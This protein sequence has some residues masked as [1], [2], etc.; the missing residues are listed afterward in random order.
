MKAFRE[1]DRVLRG[2]SGKSGAA[3]SLGPLVLANVLL[4]AFYGLCMGIYAI[5]NR[6][7]P[8]FRFLFADLIK[9]PLLFLLTL[10]VTFPSLYVFSALVRSPF[11]IVDLARLLMQS[12]GVVVALLAAFGP[13]VGF[14]SVTTRNYPFIVLLNVIVCGLSSVFGLVTFLSRLEHWLTDKTTSKKL[15]PEARDQSSQ[16]S[17]E[18]S[19]NNPQQSDAT[20]SSAEVEEAEQPV[21]TSSSSARRVFQVWIFVFGLVGLQM[22]WILRPFIGSPHAEFAWFKPRESSFFESVANTIRSL[23]G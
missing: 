15:S 3:V 13:I 18:N 22:S 17:T 5:A 2:D 12:M 16:P 19:D 9:V 7:Q 8:E 20:P 11:S 4:A 6:D 1:L 21:Q 10:I 23:F 14:F